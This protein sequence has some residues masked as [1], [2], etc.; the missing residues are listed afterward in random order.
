MDAP[1]LRAQF[2]VCEQRAYLNS[3]T[4]GPLSRAALDALTESAARATIEGRARG[5]YD[6]L[7]EVQ[8]R[9]RAAYAGVLGAEPADVALT[10]STSEGIVR[11]LAGLELA[12]GDEVVIAE[13]EHPGL[14]GPLGAVRRRL[15]LDVRIV[16][17][18][19][20]ADAVGPQTRLVACSHVAWTTGELAPSFA[21][22]A[23]DVPV[24]LDGAQG[25]GAID[26][27]VA[28]LNCAF[29]AASGQKWM[30]GPVGTGMLWIAPAWRNRLRASG[31]TYIN[32]EDPA[33]ALDAV[34]W[35]DARAMDSGLSVEAATAALAAHDVLAAHG[36]P[37]VRARA[38]ELAA[39]LA[40]R[41][42]E[43]GRDVA[44]RGPTTL[45]SWT[46]PD[47]EAESARLAD[48]GVLVRS[49]KN[50]PWVRAAV[51]AWNDDSDLDRL[52]AAL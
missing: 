15:G 26:V 3:G 46:S 33:A 41:L 28:T 50:L 9:L 24:L 16:P 34:P 27:D 40:T 2:P 48:A 38:R 6:R 12:P 39:T 43:A 29:Y 35:P 11:V 44:P 31:P 36:W 13:H 23:P 47:P 5:Y 21:G 10:T 7:L 49:F 22:L 8:P 20:V 32:L 17:L 30:C 1:A 18:A 37:E 4:C 51:G 42:A 52:L 25:A 14:L 45:V 19:Q